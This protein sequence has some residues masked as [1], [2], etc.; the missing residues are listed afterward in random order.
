MKFHWNARNR[1]RL[2]LSLA[3]VCAV[4][5]AAGTAFGAPAKSQ[6]TTL[7]ALIGSSGPAE[8]NAVNVATAAWSRKTGIRE[9]R[10]SR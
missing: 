7:T 6:D 1:W 3:V 2:V 9:K 8:T 5:V 4:A 10:E